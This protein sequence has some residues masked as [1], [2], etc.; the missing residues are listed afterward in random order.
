LGEVLSAIVQCVRD[1]GLIAFRA[2]AID[3]GG[4]HMIALFDVI[5]IASFGDN[6]TGRLVTE[7]LRQSVPRARRPLHR[8]KLRM[9]HAAGKQFHQDL[10]GTRIGKL[11]FI[12]D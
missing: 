2:V 6:D 1:Y 11:D 5:Y 9:A 4:D 12:D 3:P 7:Q 8:M 10:I